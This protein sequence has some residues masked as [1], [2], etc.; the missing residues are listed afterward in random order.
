MSETGAEA[1]QM[2]NNRG[3]ASFSEERASGTDEICKAEV[4]TMPLSCG[5]LALEPQ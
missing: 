5:G 2:S 1:R 4:S 3:A